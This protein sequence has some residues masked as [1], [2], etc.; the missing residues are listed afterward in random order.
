MTSVTVPEPRPG[1]SRRKGRADAEQPAGGDPA[2]GLRALDVSLVVLFLALTALLGVFP[3]KDADNYW[4]LRT[5]DLIRETGSIP[6]VDFYTFTREGATWIDLHWLFQVGMSWINERAGVPGLILAKVLITTLAVGLLIT[7]RR[8]TWPAWAMVLAWLP[9]LVVLSGRMYVRPE[10]LSLLYLSAYLAVLSRWERHPRLAW[11]LP[12]VQVAWVNSH[13][14][15][16]LGPIVLGFGLIDALLRLRAMGPDPARWW[17]TVAPAAV[18]VLVACLLNPYGLRGATYPLELARTMSNP[19]FSQ[20]IAE[21]TPIPLFIRNHGWTSVPL[22]IQLGTMVLGALSFLVPLAWSLGRWLLGREKTQPAA[23]AEPAGKRKRKASKNKAAAAVV[24]EEPTGWRPSV[25]RLLLFGAFTALSFQ[26]TR[27]SHQFAAVAGAVTAWNFA[28]WVA[29]I[30]RTRAAAPTSGPARPAGLTPTLATM[31]VVVSM[32]VAVAS[33]KFYEFLG[34]GRTIGWGEAPL[35]YPHDAARL[36][37]QEGMPERFIGFHN[38]H[39]SVF[40]YHNS[41]KREGGPGRRVYT[42]PRL[43]VAGPE[44]FDEYNQLSRRIAADSPGWEAELQ[45]LGLPSILVDHEYS[46][47]QGATLLA[48]RRWKCIWFDPIAALYVHES[49]ADAVRGREVDF[50]A[51]HFRPEAATEPHGT[52]ELRALARAGRYYQVALAGRSRASRAL[53]WVASDAARRLLKS[54]P[55]SFD[56]WKTIGQLEIREPLDPPSPR[57]RQPFDPV[58]DLA[59]VRATYALRRA[60]AAVPT[61]F[62]SLFSLMLVYQNRQMN[63]AVLP[64]LD[65]LAELPPINPTQRTMLGQVL[66]G[67]SEIREI[68]SRPVE[69]R[70]KNAGELDRIVNRLLAEGRAGSAC[71]VLEQ[72]YPAEK[73]PWEMVDRMATLRLHLGDPAAA[74][75]LWQRAGATAQPAVRDA[76]IAAADFAEERIEAARAGYERAIAADPAL[77]EARYGLAVLEQEVGRAPEAL[78]QAEAAVGSAANDV[79]RAAARGVADLVRPYAGAAV[80]RSGP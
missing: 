19:I 16:V 33:G 50:G 47:G 21:L 57:F 71:E 34:E 52:D 23:P 17:K 29:A 64:I 22:L 78:I 13:G 54:D 62:S 37:G 48:S 31:A 15:F 11:I 70:W 66:A 58:F 51:R 53:G 5:G 14:L 41:P 75:G 42:D 38:A 1:P 44:L 28:E 80:S 10:T 6:R 25:F 39:A 43:E 7:A 12:F 35:W 65:R 24:A 73:A 30:R 61:D 3:L 2:R 36:A 77:F 68:L 69:T 74:R 8:R 46:S 27:N 26:A 40:E 59:M 45:R 63:E 55:D 76:R 79:S 20:S 4:H 60:V 49:Y 32:L 56:G 18:A 72:A 9:A 67:R